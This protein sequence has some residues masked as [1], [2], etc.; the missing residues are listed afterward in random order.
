[1]YRKVKI[2]LGMYSNHL[3]QLPFVLFIFLSVKAS[4]GHSFF[5]AMLFQIYIWLGPNGFDITA[6]SIAHCLYS[7]TL[8]WEKI[9][10][11]TLSR[12]STRHRFDL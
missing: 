7:I 12:L 10:R 3:F 5:F 8:N 2:L 4:R 9:A 1:M 11:N 6:F